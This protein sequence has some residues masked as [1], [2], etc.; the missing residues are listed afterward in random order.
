MNEPG[1]P[2]LAT[3][4]RG[5][6]CLVTARTGE[7]V[8]HSRCGLYHRD[9]RMVSR[10][11]VTVAGRPPRLIAWSPAG[12]AG[13]QRVYLVGTHSHPAAEGVILHYRELAGG[14]RERFE[15]RALGAGPLTVTLA[16][17]VACDFAS[18]PALRYGRPLP[19]A[20]A[21]VG[22]EPYLARRGACQLRI[23]P[24]AG[25]AVVTGENARLT[26]D[27]RASP[28]QPA[29]ASLLLEPS[30]Q[31]SF[32]APAAR[33]VPPRAATGSGGSASPQ[34]T[35]S[36]GALPPREPAGSGQQH[37]EGPVLEVSGRLSQLAD[38]VA[39]GLADL[40]ALQISEPR[41]GLEFTAAGAPWFLAFFGRDSLITGWEALPAGP[42][43]AMQALR[44][45]ARH[46]GQASDP[47][48]GEEP[49]RIPHEIRIGGSEFFGIPAGEPCYD[50]VDASPLFVMLLGEAYRWGADPE[51][52]RGLLPAARG[53]LRWCL[54]HTDHDGYLR[55][56]A[57]ADG[58]RALPGAGRSPG[59]PGTRGRLANQGWKD[60]AASMVHADGTLAVPPIS[61]AEAQSYL[62]AACLALAGLEERLGEPPR[63]GPLRAAAARLRA[64]FH[65]DFWL[66]AAGLVAMA[67]D[68]SGRPLA[69]AA[70]NMAHCLWTGLLAQDAAAA[71]AT[72]LG[73]PDLS[74]GFGLRTLGATE[75]GH[76]PLGYHL[77]TVWPHDTAIAVAG[78][79]RYGHGELAVRYAADLLHAAAAFGFQLPEL[80]GG[81]S[82]SVSGRPV[83]YP[84]ACRPQAWSA[85]APLLVLRGLL[86]LDPDVPAGRLRLAPILPPDV[87]LTVHGIHL[88]TAGTVAI[89]AAGRSAE[90]LSAPPGIDVI[91]TR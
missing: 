75:R 15:L 4:T 82:R 80:Y 25:A 31:A 12:R 39:G 27:L 6:T 58:S 72:R 79:A 50:T 34:A 54:A 55:Y 43:R 63:A 61:L 41:L 1:L 64:H 62:W 2:E 44:G 20:A 18:L 57:T 33:L 37:G 85:A 81:F 36:S 24:D 76:N 8:P 88:G 19:P 22:G 32:R 59:A 91:V 90:V 77:G 45:L 52:I 3:L 67:R 83:P 11:T 49:G 86:G 46:Q 48:T 26:W 60:S 74:S 35:G 30:F 70:S 14:L 78:L 66:P 56:Q 65:R 84:L 16:V 28:G 29:T 73:A 9:I 17:T 68:G 21:I 87:T 13:D 42:A 47:A 40:A 7:I 23:D 69:V 53:A 51:E 10:L 5:D 89:R 38:A 71:V